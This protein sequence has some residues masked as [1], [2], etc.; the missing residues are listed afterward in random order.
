LKSGAAITLDAC[1]AATDDPAAAAA[2]M[3]E[4]IDAFRLGLARRL[5]SLPAQPRRMMTPRRKVRE[6]GPAR[7]RHPATR[8]GMLRGSM[9]SSPF[10]RAEIEAGRKLF[11]AD[12][13]FSSAASSL[14][15][16]PPMRGIEIAFAGRSN[17][18]K[19]SLINALAGR[20][21]LART[22]H[23]PGRTQELIFFRAPSPLVLVDMPGYGYAEASK[24]KVKAWTALIHAFLQGRANLARVYLLVDARHG[25]KATDDEV[26]ATLGKAAV[27]YQVVLTKADQVKEAELVALMAATRAALAKH[28]AAYPEVLAT[29]AHEG[30]GI[31]ELRAAIARL[32]AERGR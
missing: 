29:A 30:R 15:S 5:L 19:S 16:L 12:W 28:A 14:V 26:M 2:D 9:A 7:M 6:R 3:P 22:S 24:A 4:D 31:P 11:A 8:R 32:L 1:G 13:Q 21:A 17:V 10:T 25:L 18:G 27:N 20:H 23:T